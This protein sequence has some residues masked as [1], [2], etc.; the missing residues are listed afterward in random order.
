MEFIDIYLTLAS[1]CG[2]EP[3]EDWV[4]SRTGA[5]ALDSW[6]VVVPFP[7]PA[8]RSGLADFPHPA[9]GPACSLKL[10]RQAVPGVSGAG[11]PRPTC[12]GQSS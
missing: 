2:L 12:S 1:L 5:G 6:G 10:S 3:P 11:L 8:H 4:E 9:L 7:V